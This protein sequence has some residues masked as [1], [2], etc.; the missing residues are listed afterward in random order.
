MVVREETDMTK[1]Y[2]DEQFENLMQEYGFTYRGVI[3]SIGIHNIILN[4]FQRKCL[5][6]RTLFS[7]I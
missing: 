1:N 2:Y 7:K 6:K 5:K 3:D 4:L